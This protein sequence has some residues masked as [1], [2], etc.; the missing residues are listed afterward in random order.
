M[1][2]SRLRRVTVYSV[3]LLADLA[4]DRRVERRRRGGGVALPQAPLAA[5]AFWALNLVG[6]GVIRR[7]QAKG[8]GGLLTI[9][10]YQADA[11]DEHTCGSPGRYCGIAAVRALPPVRMTK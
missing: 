6:F 3:T 9:T 11:A 2:A 8:G 4:N 5:I 10:T 1:T 7:L